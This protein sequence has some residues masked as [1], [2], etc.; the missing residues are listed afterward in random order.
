MLAAPHIRLVC[1]AGLMVVPQQV[2]NGMDAEE[3]N[4]PLKAVS[5]QFRLLLR[6]LQRQ[7]N[8]TQ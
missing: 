1:L 5:V 8:I 2:Q 7:H 6:T 4:L 3:G